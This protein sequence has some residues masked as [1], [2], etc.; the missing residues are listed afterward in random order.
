MKQL[1][2]I[3]LFA[4]LSLFALTFSAS[5][6]EEL[7]NDASVEFIEGLTELDDSLEGE[8]NAELWLFG[9]H[10][11]FTAVDISM[12]SA[13]ID[14][15]AVPCYKIESLE[16]ATMPN[17]ATM[18]VESEAV[19]THDLFIVSYKSAKTY[20]LGDDEDSESL[21]ISL[22]GEGHHIANESS[23][24]VEDNWERD[25]FLEPGTLAG[26]LDQL[27]QVLLATKGEEG[28]SYAFPSYNA[29]V[30]AFT[31]YTFEVG[32]VSAAENVDF[33]G[34]KITTNGT[35]LSLHTDDT[36]TEVQRP[37]EILVDTWVAEGMILES[38]ARSVGADIRIYTEGAR[39]L[40]IE[41]TLS[42]IETFLDLDEK[43]DPVIAYFHAVADCDETVAPR[44]FDLDRLVD[45]IID[46]DA[47][48]AGMAAAG[49]R[50]MLQMAIT[51]NIQQSF[52]SEIERN[53]EEN[54]FNRAITLLF[55]ED[56]FEVSE[57]AKK[58]EFEVRFIEPYRTEVQGLGFTFYVSE[59]DGEFR[60]VGIKQ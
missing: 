50:P 17:G 38:N 23:Y 28:E 33:E 45:S 12:D 15:E 14:G 51:Q 9:K 20:K 59:V 55:N 4:F 44:V 21:T 35:D 57:A 49:Q 53:R 27:I 36:G 24:K 40:E 1:C 31:A 5:A 22:S 37:Q 48:L 41:A 47:N 8:T 7:F 46:G 25:V 43:A 52:R 60:I 32:G 2:R 58:G 10:V 11:G 26:P 13:E 29:E 42:D 16:E 54:A 39:D 3:S 19:I 30:D 18:N 6:Q 34:V 56:S